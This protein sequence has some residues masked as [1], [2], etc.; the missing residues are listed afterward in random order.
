LEENPIRNIAKKIQSETS[1]RLLP[2]NEK[3]YYRKFSGPQIYAGW[4]LFLQE[5]IKVI[6]IIV[7]K[8]FSPAL[9]GL[10]IPR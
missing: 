3:N 2:F 6:I 1:P 8:N 7:A 9:G 10:Q 4:L 5:Q